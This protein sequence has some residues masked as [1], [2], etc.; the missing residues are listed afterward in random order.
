MSIYKVIA[1]DKGIGNITVS[2]DDDF[3]PVSIDVP[4]GDD[5][6]YLTGQALDDYIKGFIPT[7]HLE[8]IAKIAAGIP[9]S[10]E[11]EALVEVPPAPTPAEEEAAA[12]AAMWAELQREKEI[13]RAL[14]K[15]GVLEKDPTEIN[16]TIL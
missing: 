3:A 5:G 6:L 10:A 12:N 4:I 16:T 13:A 1:F 14:V 15:F 7:W 9:N 2:Y 11:I 8:R